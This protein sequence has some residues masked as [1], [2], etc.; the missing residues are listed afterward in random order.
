MARAVD[1]DSECE[2]AVLGRRYPGTGV[3]DDDRPCRTHTESAGS[4]DE[5]R[6]RDAI[7]TDTEK[8][9]NPSGFQELSTARA[10]HVGSRGDPD[11][12]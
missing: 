4:F 11:A 5:G 3:I 10:Q 1:T 6:G 9:I 12:E 2:T 7:D 8:I